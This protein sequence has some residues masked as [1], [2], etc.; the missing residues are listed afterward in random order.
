M[1][2]LADGGASDSLFSA[3]RTVGVVG[4]DAEGVISAWAGAARHHL[5][6]T[7]E[8]AVGM[9]AERLLASPGERAAV[10]RAVERAA[11]GAGASCSL[12]LRHRDGRR[13]T[14]GVWGCP[15]RDVSG[16]HGWIALLTTLDD[17]RWRD[18]EGAVVDAL[19]SQGPIGL[20]VLDGDLRYI[21][22]NA[23]LEQM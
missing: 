8:E 22:V 20:A 3:Y 1:D 11:A 15:L 16:S 13:V 7:V 21:A 9:P 4:V 6:Y 5:G 14:L 12:V 10:R 17:L 2:V 18:V 19:F 23:A